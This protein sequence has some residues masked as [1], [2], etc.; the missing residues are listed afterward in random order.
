MGQFNKKKK[1]AEQMR[2]PVINIII[3]QGVYQKNLT[4]PQILTNLVHKL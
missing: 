3:T 4:C 2:K 1:R